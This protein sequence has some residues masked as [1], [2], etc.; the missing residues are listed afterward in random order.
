MEG[1]APGTWE[2]CWPEF[3]CHV[4]PGSTCQKDMDIPEGPLENGGL[5]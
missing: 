4:V 3:T 1:L 5:L 2:V